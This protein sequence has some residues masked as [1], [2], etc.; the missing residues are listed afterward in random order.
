[1]VTRSFI[2]SKVLRNV[3]LSWSLHQAPSLPHLSTDSST[4]QAINLHKSQPTPSNDVYRLVLRIHPLRPCNLRAPGEVPVLPQVRLL[5]RRWPRV[6][7]RRRN[8]SPVLQAQAAQRRRSECED[9]L[10]NAQVGLDQHKLA[11]NLKHQALIPYHEHKH[12][13][14]K[15]YTRRREI[16]NCWAE[17]QG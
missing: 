2:G 17:S 7:P 1:M 9:V 12:K 10:G 15:Q 16:I 14:G 5:R 8:L 4:H 3:R 6:P 11:L 13:H